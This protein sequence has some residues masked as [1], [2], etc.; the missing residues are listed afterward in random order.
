MAAERDEPPPMGRLASVPTL[1]RPPK[2]LIETKQQFGSWRSW[3]VLRDFL[4][5]CSHWFKGQ[6]YRCY[7]LCSGKGGNNG[8][9]GGRPAARRT[10][11]KG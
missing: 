5:G 9:A 11:T 4:L 7:T 3:G 2:T 6:S 10:M 8:A 1:P